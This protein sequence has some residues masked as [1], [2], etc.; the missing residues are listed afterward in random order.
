MNIVLIGYRCCGK[1]TV[2][3]LLARD[4]EW[5]FL[6]TDRLIEGKTGIPV[7]S[8]VSQNGWRDF[9]AVEKEVVE[10]IASRDASVIATGGG[11]VI[12]QENMRNLRK[13]GWVVWLDTEVP[14][15]KDRMKNAQNS[16]ELRP[17]LSGADPLVETYVILK[18]RRPFYERASD[19]TVDTNGLPPQE[20]SQVIMGALPQWHKNNLAGGG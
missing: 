15:I 1:T 9:R 16:G 14:V 10:A 18:E 17:P 8:Y 2:G 13:N 4:L 6:D 11:V 3:S 7:H 19:Y 5:D 20:V 12:D